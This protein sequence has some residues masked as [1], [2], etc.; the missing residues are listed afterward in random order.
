MYYKKG[1]IVILFEFFVVIIII[2]G[3]FLISVL[4]VQIDLNLQNIRFE[5]HSIVKNIGLRNCNKEL[6]KSDI[7]Y[8]NFNNMK[9]ELNE[10]LNINYNNVSL[11]N[12][13]YN[14]K[15]NCFYLELIIR[16]NS[17]SGFINFKSLH[18]IVN[19]KI[20]FKTME[21]AKI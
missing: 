3:I 16:I 11:K 12:I 2:F 15:N 4:Y 8:F 18:V 21:V 7:Y 17:I 19:E 9:R 6:L 5:L 14:N 10:I 20:K 13:E 1:N